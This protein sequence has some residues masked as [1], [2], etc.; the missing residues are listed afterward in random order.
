MSA[1]AVSVLKVADT[2]TRGAAR[3]REYSFE[4]YSCYLLLSVG[5]L[6]FRPWHVR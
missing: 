3:L 1:R 4:L 6:R 2:A 5:I